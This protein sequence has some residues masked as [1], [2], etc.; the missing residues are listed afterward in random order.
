MLR[1]ITP[2]M[3]AQLAAALKRPIWL[4][5][6]DFLNGTVY[7]ASTPFAVTWN[8]K[9]WFG[10]GDLGQISPASESGTIQAANFTLALSGIPNYLLNDALNEVGPNQACKIWLGCLDA[11]GNVIADPTQMFGGLMDV[12]TIKPGAETCTIS[13]TVETRAARMK[14]AKSRRYTDADQQTDYPGDLGFQYV[15]AVTQPFMW[16]GNVIT[17]ASGGG[18]PI[19][20]PPGNPNT[21]KK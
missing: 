2:A 6:C 20:P 4:V 12:P 5:E 3:Q 8:G 17:P 14:T 1:G 21:G 7:L 19:L 18:T 16:G 9:L 11:N 10:V 15:T 13:I